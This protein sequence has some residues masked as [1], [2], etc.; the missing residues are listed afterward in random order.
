MGENPSPLGEDFS[1]SITLNFFKMIVYLAII[2]DIKIKEIEVESMTKDYVKIRGID[3]LRRETPFGKYCTTHIEAK[4]YLEKY[5]QRQI[6]GFSKAIEDLKENLSKVN[7][8]EA[9]QQV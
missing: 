3:P 9:K 7:T 2:D 1:L 4:K 5:F 6:D 8:L